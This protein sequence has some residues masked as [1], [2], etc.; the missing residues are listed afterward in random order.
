MTA[1]ASSTSISGHT[2]VAGTP[3]IAAPG[4][5]YAVGFLRRASERLHSG[6]LPPLWGGRLHCGGRR[7]T[8]NEEEERIIIN[9]PD[10][11]TYPEEKSVSTS[12]ATPPLGLHAARK[13]LNYQ[14]LEGPKGLGSVR[15]RTRLFG[16]G[17]LAVS[18]LSGREAASQEKPLLSP[19]A[20]G[21]D[22]IEVGSHTTS[23][24]TACHRSQEWPPALSSAQLAAR[25]SAAC[26]LPD[27]RL[28]F[29]CSLFAFSATRAKVLVPAYASAGGSWFASTT[30]VYGERRKV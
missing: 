1:P 9:R 20:K 6:L 7:L 28:G 12:G 22:G 2:K 26:R 11:S 14:M 16:S 30:T 15:P 29:R 19:G 8:R 13:A 21:S 10:E 25:Q 5:L 4:A 23:A 3:R 24:A 17:R 18:I 27:C